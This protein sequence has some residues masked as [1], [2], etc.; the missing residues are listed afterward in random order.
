MGCAEDFVT[1]RVLDGFGD[2]CS[3]AEARKQYLR[4]V[5]E[6]VDQDDDALLELLSSSSKACGSEAFRRAVEDRFRNRTASLGRYVDVSMRRRETAVPAAEV[7]A[8]VA[9]AYGLTEAELLRRGNREAKD[10]WMRLLHE[11]GG[12]AQRE[13]GRLAGHCDGST[14]SG[15]LARLASALADDPE[16]R[17]RYR[18]LRARIPKSKA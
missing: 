2:A 9:A 6:A 16:C 3:E 1:Y 7:T 4:Y 14:V 17:S 15:C 13:I 8:M 18:A 12:L 11:E 10:F 5:E